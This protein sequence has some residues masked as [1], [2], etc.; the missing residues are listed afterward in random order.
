MKRDYQSIENYV[1]KMDPLES[2]RVAQEEKSPRRILNKSVSKA[3]ADEST[4]GVAL[5][6]HPPQ[7]AKTA[8]SPSGLR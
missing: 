5:L 1:G 3:A 6:T 8:C 7:A 4:A 2:A